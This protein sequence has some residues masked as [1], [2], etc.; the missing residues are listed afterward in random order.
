[1]NVPYL[2]GVNVE[3]EDVKIAY[4]SGNLRKLIC[5]LVNYSFVLVFIN[6]T[7]HSIFI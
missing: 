4:M 7:I 1:V 5:L 2:K 6:S 3:V